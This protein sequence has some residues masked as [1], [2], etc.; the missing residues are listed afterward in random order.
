M[1]DR[2]LI[3]GLGSIGSRHAR[4]ARLLLPK[5]QIGALRHK[6]YKIPENVEID[7]CFTDINQAMHF[8]PQASVIANPATS[9]IAVAL[10]LSDIGSHLLIEKPIA[11]KSAEV[12]RLINLCQ[13]KGLT[14]MTGY[15]LRFL[16]SQ[17]KFKEFLLSGYIGNVFS[18]RCEVGHYLP[19]WR[20]QTD[21]KYT[22]SARKVLGGGVLLELSHEI[23]YLR[24]IFGEVEWVQGVMLQQSELEIDVEDTAHI[25]MGF[26]SDFR[27]KP[28]VANI[29]MD[30]I[31]FDP[32]RLCTVIG[33]QGSLRW[34][35]LK[36]TVELFRQG[37]NEWETMFQD[38]T[39]INDTYINE[40]QNFLASIQGLAEPL[41]TGQDGLAVLKIIEAIRL[42]SKKGAMI[43]LHENSL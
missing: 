35:G 6:S 30:F 15:N 2:L 10:K 28:V 24:W 7:C 19:Y 9:H 41:V 29:S 14:L 13:N 37:S 34:N 22:V 18:V 42:S 1:I 32:V 27:K 43:K 11:E 40:W 5:A 4:I 16:P 12:E 31:R 25:N 36:G 26:K 3:V 8:L 17:Q 39:G 21:Y 33:E 20:P 23:D 38:M